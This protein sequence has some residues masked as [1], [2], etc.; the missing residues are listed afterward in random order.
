M[1][2]NI[3]N[4]IRGVYYEYAGKRMQIV[5]ELENIMQ[6]QY[7]L[8]NKKVKKL[9]NKLAKYNTLLDAINDQHSDVTMEEK[10]EPDDVIEAEPTE[11]QS[12]DCCGNSCGC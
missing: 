8:N 2:S 5:S 12:E 9:Y 4:M 10:A 7:Q 6:H 11:S 3:K 1:D